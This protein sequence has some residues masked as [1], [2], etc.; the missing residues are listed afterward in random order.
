MQ[1]RLE[2]HLNEFLRYILIFQIN[3]FRFVLY[4]V[5]LVFSV[6]YYENLLIFSLYQS[7]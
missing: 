3:T 7:A 1:L 6:T 5:F 4:Q 2:Q